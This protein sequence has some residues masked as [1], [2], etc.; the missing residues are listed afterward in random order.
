MDALLE[1]WP[2]TLDVAEVM[3]RAEDRFA[4]GETAAERRR[5]TRGVLAEVLG[6][7]LVSA[8]VE[9]PQVAVRAGAAP[10]ASRLA[11]RQ[12]EHGPEV[13][14]LWHETVSLD[15]AFAKRL[16]MLLDGTG[17]REDLV[18]ALGGAWSGP[19]GELAAAIERHLEHIARLALLHS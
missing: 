13:T 7:G 15:D 16:L 5:F 6:L 18:A 17:S 4:P 3:G 2:A 8:A 11:R 1:A 14:N 12:L 9:P 10:A 19:A